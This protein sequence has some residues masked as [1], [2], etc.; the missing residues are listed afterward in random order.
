MTRNCWEF[1]ECGREPGG[2]K[3][4]LLGVCPAAIE[5]RLSGMNGGKN[6]GRACWMVNNTLYG[7]FGRDYHTSKLSS[8]CQCDFLALVR[9]EE[10][11]SFIW[12]PDI[13][14]LLEPER[15]PFL[16]D[17]RIA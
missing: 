5:D 2:V 7:S 8:C 11:N 10:G 3:V 9:K 12:R 13:P 14:A 6:G 4:P 1:C 16:R 15:R 17:R